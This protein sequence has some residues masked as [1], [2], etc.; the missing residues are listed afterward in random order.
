VLG[1]SGGAD[2]SAV[3]QNEGDT[4][5]LNLTNANLAVTQVVTVR[6]AT[7]TNTKTTLVLDIDFS[8]T[9][10]SLTQTG[11]G[12][13]TIE[14]TLSNAALDY[15]TDVDYDV[16]FVFSGGALRTLE[17]TDCSGILTR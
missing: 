10:G 14:A 17:T 13:Q 1:F 4:V 3:L 16:N 5:T 6:T 8:A 9:G 11:S 15:R 12:V 2:Q 7:F